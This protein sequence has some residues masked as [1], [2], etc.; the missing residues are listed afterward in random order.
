MT[1]NTS[2]ANVAPPSP[3]ASPRPSP[4]S[5]F[6]SGRNLKVDN[7]T[8]PADDHTHPL[9]APLLDAWDLKYNRRSVPVMARKDFELLYTSLLRELGSSAAI[10]STLEAT[11]AGRMQREIHKVK[12]QLELAKSKIFLRVDVADEMDDL[13][14]HVQQ[15]NHLGWSKY[16]ICTLP[17]LSQLYS[18][19]QPATTEMPLP[20]NSPR[21]PTQPQPTKQRAVRIGKTRERVP[22]RRSDRIKK[23]TRNGVQ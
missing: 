14:P 7:G 11:L 4:G 22:V 6:V 3:A 12:T 17:V 9:P 18:S 20:P 8:Q 19:Q 10:D 16:I 5:S 15:E 23:L 13:A 2:A 1:M 21:A